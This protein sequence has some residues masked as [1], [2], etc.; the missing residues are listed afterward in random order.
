M[1]RSVD[2]FRFP[3]T[4]NLRFALLALLIVAISIFAYILL[5]LFVLRSPEDFR[6]MTSCAELPRIPLDD[7]GPTSAECFRPINQRA[8]RFVVF[9][10]GALA[11]LAVVAY[12]LDPLWRIRRG[13]F[14]PIQALGRA[15]LEKHLDALAAGA[16]PRHPP[17]FRIGEAALRPSAFTLPGG[18]VVLNHALLALYLQGELTQFDGYV[19]HEIAHIRNGDALQAYGTLALW[20]VF[21][22]CVVLPMV[23]FT[24]LNLT[25]RSVEV[26]A[27]IAVL[28][29]LVWLVRN[30]VLRS[31]ELYADARASQVGDGAERI[32]A[33]L[34]TLQETQPTP[35]LWRVHPTL[36]DRQQ[37]L[38]DTSALMRSGTLE[39]GAAGVLAGALLPSVQIL[40]NLGLSGGILVTAI[41]TGALAMAPAAGLV[42]IALWRSEY[43]HL[44]G[45]AAA[46]TGA[47]SAALAVGLVVGLEL[48]PLSRYGLGATPLQRGP[49]DAIWMFALLAATVLLVRWCGSTARVWLSQVGDGARVY[50][51]G[52]VIPVAV[53]ALTFAVLRAGRQMLDDFVTFGLLDAT[54]V[55]DF[56][57]SLALALTDQPILLLVAT[58]VAVYP[59]VPLLRR[60]GNMRGA[61]ARAVVGIVL[62]YAVDMAVIYV[63]RE[64]RPA[65]GFTPEQLQGI[66]NARHVLAAAAC[67]LVALAVAYA[68]RVEG[69]VWGILF[70]WASLMIV[71]L[72]LAGAV[73]P[74]PDLVFSDVLA[75]VSSTVVTGLGVVVAGA[76]LGARLPHARPAPVFAQP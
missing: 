9:G 54:E 53:I 11:V 58:L 69:A 29:G 7:G 8:A 76:W 56:A 62:F 15:D 46:G 21:L 34:A 1:N 24:V 70:G 59:A 31:R 41:V 26:L 2:P 42:C 43:V 25:T 47:L 33:A 20:R 44:R 23:L 72:R 75:L 36:S 16:G 74:L 32:R 50:W 45:G 10:V 19:L 57:W 37:A 35:L 30:A 61:A 39:A 65:G 73:P 17:R 14:R 55:T 27:R 52:I 48:S 5:Y 12:R 38:A 6:L 60:I 13:K 4:T 3:S 18:T 49:L 63:V 51:P 67:G 64:M 22:L 71:G 28:G 40:T 68:T 66:S